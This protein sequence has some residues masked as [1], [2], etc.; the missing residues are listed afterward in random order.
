MMSD[1]PIRKALDAIT[2][3]QTGLAETIKAQLPAGTRV[4]WIRS[5]HRQSGTVCRT[6]PHK[7]LVENEATGRRYWLSP[8]YFTAKFNG[9]IE[10]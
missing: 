1:C 9:G 2:S 5:G 4:Y 7:V 8:E 10:A 3:A 6:A